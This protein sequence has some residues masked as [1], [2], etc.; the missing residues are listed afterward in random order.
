LNTVRIVVNT[1]EDSRLSADFEDSGETITV[2][3]SR[4]VSPF[5]FTAYP[6]REENG[7]LA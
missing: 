3:I 6:E 2:R 5:L 4:K 7:K 1:E